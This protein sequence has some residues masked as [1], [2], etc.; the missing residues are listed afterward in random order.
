MIQDN[1]LKLSEN[2]AFNAASALYDDVQ[3][4][5]GQDLI[6]DASAVQHIDANCAQILLAAEKMWEPTES[7][8]VLNA[9]SEA[10]HAGL[11]DLG[12]ASFFNQLPGE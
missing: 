3:E 5:L 9:C 6:I 10:F 12:L 4:R 2:L 11:D 8:F 1:K 7:K